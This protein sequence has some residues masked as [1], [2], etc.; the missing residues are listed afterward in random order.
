MGENF[1]NKVGS[2]VDVGL[3]PRWP[4]D[5]LGQT[6]HRF[7]TMFVVV[8]L[9]CSCKVLD[10]LYKTTISLVCKEIGLSVFHLSP[11]WHMCCPGTG[12]TR[13]SHVDHMWITGEKRPCLLWEPGV[14]SEWMYLPHITFD[15]FSPQ[16]TPMIPGSWS[17]ASFF[18]E[19]RAQ[20]VRASRCLS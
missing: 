6:H 19:L 12:G 3:V 17:P 14:S 4:D 20:V 1:F 5:W 15:C 13:E 9:S 2:I 16:S 7:L 8:A 10:V 11:L 18:K